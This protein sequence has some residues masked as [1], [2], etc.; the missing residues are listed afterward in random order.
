MNGNAR[1]GPFLV[2]K[3]SHEIV[4]AKFEGVIIRLKELCTRMDIIV[5]RLRRRPLF[6]YNKV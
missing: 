1:L 5:E 2:G 6:L 4:V 3:N